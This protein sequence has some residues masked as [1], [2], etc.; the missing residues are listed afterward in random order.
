MRVAGVVLAA[1]ASRRLGEP[2]QLVEYGGEPL[3]RAVANAVCASSCDRVGVVVGAYAAQVAAALDGVPVTLLP[4]VLWSE[5]MAASVRC[6]A[7]WA[8]RSAC[9]VLVLCVCDQPRLTTTHVDRLV[10]QHRAHGRAVGSRYGDAIG[11]PAVFGA[12]DYPQLAHLSGDEG[13]RRMLARCAIDV[14]DWPDGAFDIDLAR[15]VLAIA[16]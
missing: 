1:G 7:A 4:N 15:D 11:V 14:V 13:A 6:A 16:S 10:A 3:V 9:D 8:A 2:K 12:A 5:G